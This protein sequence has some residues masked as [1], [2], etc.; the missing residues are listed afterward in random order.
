M[1]ISVDSVLSVVIDFLYS[2][3]NDEIDGWTEGLGIIPAH[4]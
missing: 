2:T 3:P 4:G 1:K